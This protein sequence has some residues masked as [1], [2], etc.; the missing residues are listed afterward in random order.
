M[1]AWRRRVRDQL[2][3]GI[4]PW[5]R[6]DRTGSSTPVYRF[7]TYHRVRPDQREDFRR[8]LDRLQARYHFVT[9]REFERNEGSAD[10]LNLLLTFDDGYR[11]W[12]TFV[13]EEL[14]D[15]GL[16][17]VFFVCPDFVDLDEREAARYCREH[18]GLR[19]APPLTEGGVRRLA[20]DHTLGNHLLA[21][22]DL[23]EAT[24]PATLQEVFET[25][26]DAFERRFGHRPSWLAYPFGDYF[27]APGILQETA[28]RCFDY[29]LTLVPGTNTADTPPGLLHRE[30]FA[31]DLDQSV[32]VNWLQGGF[33][34]L[35]WLTHLLRPGPTFPARAEANAR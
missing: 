28:L 9:P 12:E 13:L 27:R 25:S 15:R 10:R 17:A 20:R 6:P 5:C 3:R 30:G 34:P 11:E 16:E 29:A 26:Q 31:P 33:E 24:D 7:L 19:P 22:R 21:H 18:L 23:R 14:N 32:E 8:Q 35:F 1:T 2:I 4:G